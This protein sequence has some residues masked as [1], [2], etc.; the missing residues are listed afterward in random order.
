MNTRLFRKLRIKIVWISMIMLMVLMVSFCVTVYLAMAASLK[1]NSI[2]VLDYTAELV[3]AEH[4]QDNA[5]TTQPSGSDQPLTANSIQNSTPERPES[6]DALL[7]RNVM[8]VYY[9]KTGYIVMV[10]QGGKAIQHMDTMGR[11]LN[12]SV[13]E[14]I[15]QEPDGIVTIKNDDYRYK[16]IYAGKTPILLLVSRS[17]ELANLPSLMVILVIVGISAILILFVA[18]ILLSGHIV[19]PVSEAW[20][21]Q[22]QFLHDASHELKTPLAVIATNLEAVRASPDETV[23]SQDKWLQYAAEET[24]DMRQ[25][26]N[27]ML[28]LAKSDHPDFDIQ[29]QPHIPFLLSETVTEVGL[30]ME[31]NALEAGIDLDIQ[32]EDDL[33][34]VG[35]EVGIKHVLLILLDNALKNTFA[36]GKIT[37][38]LHR[39][40]NHVLVSCTNTGHGIPKEELQNIFKR[41]YR[42]DP[43]RARESGGSGLGLSIAES[44]I[45]VHNGKI[46][47]ES[48]LDQYARFIFRLPIAHKNV[49]S[50]K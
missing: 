28:A 9:D 38:E 22:Q 43:S 30:T 1:S 27:Y 2:A 37:L 17:G 5:N 45:H 15:G 42:V 6:L 35:V 24:E 49:A 4:T 23:A 36:G 3:I 13:I 10:K 39:N 47:A 14:Q 44:I 31:A 20:T 19:R 7:L 25:M 26:V 16:H 21:T 40:R 50:P 34:V 41:F 32:V 33:W 8:I 11:V 12:E 46:W 48:E 18:C 29:N